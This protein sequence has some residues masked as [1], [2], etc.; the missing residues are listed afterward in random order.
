MDTTLLE[1]IGKRAENVWGEL[2]E[3][4]PELCAFDCPEVALNNR[5]WRTAGQCY[6]D[7]RK[8]FL[9]SKFYAAGFHVRMNKIILPH[10]LIHQADFD[11]F[12][13]SEKRCGHGKNWARLMLEYGLE[14]DIYHSMQLTRKGEKV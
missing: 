8:V 10:E 7:S 2:C 5:M 4:H 3:I 1:D 9:S 6:Q 14:P 12:G 11:L 13:I